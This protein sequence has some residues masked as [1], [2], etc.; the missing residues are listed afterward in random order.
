MLGM[1]KILN[2]R[3][4][5]MNY[6]DLVHSA[7]ANRSF[8]E[9]R[10]ISKDELVALIDLARHTPAAMNMQPLK[11]RLVYEKEELD[12]TLAITA[13]GGAL[14][15]LK[16]PP[17]GHAP[18]A[19]IVVCHDTSIAEDSPMFLIDVGIASQTISLGA[20]DMG[21]RTCMLGSAKAEDLRKTLGIP[22]GLI[23]KLTIA[24]GKGEDNVKIVDAKDGSIKYFRDENNV[25]YV[26]KRTLE[27][28]II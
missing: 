25:H 15:E 24:L 16:L 7:R 19:Y 27:E 11:F 8:D 20:A 14:P 2:Q 18:T 23:P 4:A 3:R 12:K 9:G 21:L 28:I 17:D 26:P 6:K 22:E 10:A 1:V 13:W 5:F